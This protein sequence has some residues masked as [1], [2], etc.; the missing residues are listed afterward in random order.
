M[1]C[2]K[3]LHSDVCK[4][5]QFPK[6]FGLTDEHCDSFKDEDLYIKL[7]SEVSKNNC[8]ATNKSKGKCT[9]CCAYCYRVDCDNRCK[10]DPALCGQLNKEDA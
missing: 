6:L 9:K 1:N 5:K 10:N 3:C 7:P 8:G 2:N 4:M